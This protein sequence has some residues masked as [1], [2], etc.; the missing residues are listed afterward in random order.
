MKKI[1]YFFSFVLITL[2]VAGSCG[3][4][5]QTPPSQPETITS[6]ATTIPEPSPEPEQPSLVKKELELKYDDGLYEAWFSSAGGGYLIDFTP[7]AGPFIINAINICGNLSER[8]GDRDNFDLEI[9]GKNNKV[10]YSN[11]FPVTE[12]PTDSPDWITIEIPNIEVFDQFS[13]HVFAGSFLNTGIAVAVD[14]SLIN[15]HSKLTGRTSEGITSIIDMKSDMPFRGDWVEKNKDKINW[16]IRVVG[17][18]MEPE[19]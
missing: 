13:I 7:P 1:D 11:S 9:W 6:P 16:M 8:T 19:R 4:P 15:E 10:L 18:Y 14:N 12:F 2:L 17:T 3:T 5:E